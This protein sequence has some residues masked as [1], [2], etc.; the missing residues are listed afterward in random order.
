[1]PEQV[2]AAPPPSRELIGEMLSW[3]PADTETVLAAN[4]P[5][6]MPMPNTSQASNGGVG[7]EG[8]G[9][10][11]RDSFKLPLELLGFMKN[12]NFNDAS[13][14]AAMEGSRDFRPPSGLGMAMFQG[15]TVAVFAD[16]ISAR[17]RRFLKDSGPTFVRTEQIGGQDVAVFKEKAEEDIWTTYVAFPKRNIAVVATDESYLREVLARINGKQGERALPDTLPEW[18]YVNTHANFWAV[19]HFRHDGGR[20]S[21]TSGFSC[22]TSDIKPNERAVGFAYSF[23]PKR[24]K[25]AT[26]TYLSGD[27]STLQTIQKSLFSEREAGVTEMHAQYRAV[28]DGV[29]EGT[30]NLEKVSSTQS[31]LFILEALLGH[32][33]YI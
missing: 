15:A 19:R 9:D 12:F 31:F 18:R 4:G 20:A 10:E 17:A 14:V 24:S 7:T 8:S 29:L 30:Y 16:D 1:M 21:L 33:I 22:I 26:I 13:I 6:L 2:A 32:A 23:D 25:V 3:F 5:L 28:Q 11:V 27:E